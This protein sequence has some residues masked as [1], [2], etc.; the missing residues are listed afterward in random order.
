MILQK[1]KELE[2]EAKRKFA[3]NDR[4]VVK[5]GESSSTTERLVDTPSEDISNMS[6]DRKHKFA[7]FWGPSI[8]ETLSN[9]TMVKPDKT[10]RN[11]YNNKPLKYKELMPV[12]FTPI[13]ESKTHSQLV[14]SQNRYMCPVTKDTLTNAMK[15]AY[16][17][18]SQR[19]VNAACVEMIVKDGHDPING[20]ELKKEDVIFM[21]KGGTGFARTNMLKANV[22]RPTMAT[23]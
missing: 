11:P 17:K 8:P 14:G 18:T 12:I 1:K 9:G 10:V 7:S 23:A 3:Y 15:C 5:S 20:K 21:Q 22:Y 6:G 2:D 4:H 19:V 13:D 16:L